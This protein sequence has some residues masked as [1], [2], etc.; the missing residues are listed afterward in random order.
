MPYLE[1]HRIL[2]TVYYSSSA[3]EPC[4]VVPVY[5]FEITFYWYCI[6]MFHL[7]EYRI[8]SSVYLIK[9]QADIS[10]LFFSMLLHI[11]IREILR[12]VRIFRFFSSPRS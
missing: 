1:E 9:L 5:N 2:S 8:L 3:G 11:W 10:V 12:E 7:E 4:D 6:Q